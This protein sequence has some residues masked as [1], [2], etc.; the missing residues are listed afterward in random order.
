M[1]ETE[2]S[3]SSEPLSARIRQDVPHSARM[4]DYFLGGKDNYAVDREAAERVLQVF[5]N[6]R[7][8]VRA[9]RAFMRRSTRALAELGLRQWLDIGTGIPTSP[10]LHEVAQSVA[11]D[12]RVVYVDHDPVVLAHSR[13]L[14][15]STPEGRTAYIHGDVRDPEAILDAPQLAETLDLGQPVVLSMVALLHFVPD[16]REAQ[17]IVDRLFKPLPSGSALVLSHATAE[18]DPEGAPKVQEIYNQVGTT[19]QLRNREQFASF[20]DGL[21]L[22]EPEIVT[23]HRW[24]PDDGDD[25]LP[26]DATDAQVSFYAAVGIKP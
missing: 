23:A 24:R 7:L 19:L 18:L 15:T 6:M 14:M 20:F 25:P 12:A 5:P 26:G 16:I 2:G 22:L 10:N 4:Y 17:A 1:S 21:E 11:P 13:A 3:V 9:N 8:A